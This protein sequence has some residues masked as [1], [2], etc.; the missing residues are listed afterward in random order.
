MAYLVGRKMTNSS[1]PTLTTS[2]TSLAVVASSR[3]VHWGRRYSL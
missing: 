2:D 3:S 1:A